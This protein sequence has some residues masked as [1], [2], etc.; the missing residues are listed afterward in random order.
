MFED[1]KV[2]YLAGKNDLYVDELLRNNAEMYV[3]EHFSGITGAQRL[4]LENAYIAG[5]Y[6]DDLYSNYE[7]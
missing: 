7:E 4:E 2:C 3:R 5:F 6:R 1:I